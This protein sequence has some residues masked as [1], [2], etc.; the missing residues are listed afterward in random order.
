[1]ASQRGDT[2]LQL[3]RETSL[4]HDALNHIILTLNQ[5]LHERAPSM[6]ST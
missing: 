4:S 2:R 1:M 3:L 5:L 6:A